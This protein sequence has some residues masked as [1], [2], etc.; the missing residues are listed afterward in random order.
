MIPFI[1]FEI[2]VHLYKWIGTVSLA[3]YRIHFCFILLLNINFVDYPQLI[4]P[5]YFSEGNKSL[6]RI[7]KNLLTLCGF[8]IFLL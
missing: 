5:C 1:I 8:L 6:K 2:F 4:L 7:K 3:Y